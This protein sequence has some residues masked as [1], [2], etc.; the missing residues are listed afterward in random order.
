M[1]VALLLD[2]V[3]APPKYR[4]ELRWRLLWLVF[5]LL[6]LI[7]TLLRGA[8]VDWYPYPFL[9]P[10]RVGGYAGVAAYS[11]VILAVFVMFAA[12]LIWLGDYL[13]EQRTPIA[14][15]REK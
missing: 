3:C 6:F 8:S 13:R 5:P 1:P 2:W 7:Y 12:L 11:V 10:S 15:K 14:S 4:L 9:D